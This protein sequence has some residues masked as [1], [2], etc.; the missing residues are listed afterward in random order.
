MGNRERIG[1]LL[2]ARFGKAFTDE[3]LVIVEY[4][5]TIVGM[6]MLKS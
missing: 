2:L 5:A 1:T 3:D 6:E 4:S